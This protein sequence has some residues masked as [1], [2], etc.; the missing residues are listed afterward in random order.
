MKVPAD[1]A[2]G[3]HR[4]MKPAEWRADGEERIS[5]R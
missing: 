2:D 5:R 3:K 1:L 4:S